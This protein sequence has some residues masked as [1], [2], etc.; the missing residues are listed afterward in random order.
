LSI[1]PLSPFSS[2]GFLHDLGKLLFFYGAESQWDV[3]GDTF[4]VGC[5][6]DREAI[7]YPNTFDGNP[8][9]NHEVYGTN[10]GIYKPDCGI[11]NVMLSW[12]HDGE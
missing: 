10:Y 4:V 8:D 6:F 5:A 1:S 3:V 2:L 9:V 11:D 7:V 12:G